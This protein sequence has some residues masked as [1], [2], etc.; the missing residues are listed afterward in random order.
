[1]NHLTEEQLSACVD[2]ALPAAA[3]AAAEAH[4]AGC[5]TCRA[6]LETMRAA[7]TLFG[8]VL[9][10]DP[11]DAYF[12]TFASRVAE[13]IGAE[14][15]AAPA[16]AAAPR[17][18]A[19]EV[20]GT[21]RRPPRS[22]A[23]WWD[24]ASWFTAPAR[25]AWVG[26]VA[27]VVVVAGVA[28][29]LARE[30]GVPDLRDAKTLQGSRQTEAREAAPAAPPAASREAD[31]R[32]ARDA[33][34]GP[35]AESGATG[36]TSADATS[37]RI[38]PPSHAQQ[39]RRLPGG[40]EVPVPRG[41]VPPFAQP[42]SP[43]PAPQ[44]ADGTVKV[45]RPQRAAPLDAKAQETRAAA[46]NETTTP[47]TQTMAKRATSSLG[48][49]GTRES[50]SGAAV[51]SLQLTAPGAC[52]V[53]VD[54]QGRPIARAQV[55]L[56]DRGVTATTSDAGRFCFDVAQGDYDLTVL[57]VGFTPLRR[58]VRLGDP[59]TP[60]R[61]VVQTVEVLAPASPLPPRPGAP[62]PP[63]G[64]GAEL[65][66]VPT[67]PA[68]VPDDLRAT[69][70]DARRLMIEAGA[71]PDAGRYE[72]AVEAWNGVI[73]AL[74]DG[75]A[76]DLEAREH[77]ADA[78]YAAWVL[79]ATPARNAAAREALHDLTVRLPEGP[80]RDRVRRLLARLVP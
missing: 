25:L 43:A 21:E 13:R 40:E 29:M 73:A 65:L 2:G 50:L 41:D 30:G 32:L 63:P 26:G 74:P 31:D 5:E 78:L 59:N 44:S 28:L 36:R 20:P 12:R 34:T 64:V 18:P 42:P 16:A 11:G 48:A 47:T 70:N 77:R 69:W 37:E 23:P 67:A 60:V 7:D 58:S 62:S 51:P 61:L 39:V 54:A 79:E 68:D 1:M 72:A 55:V 76:A 15:A 14:S 53:V 38:A 27:A 57:A 46:K 8:E 9:T 75:G 3:Q 10:H 66:P 52:G 22:G 71:D 49:S 6:A 35:A 80:R 19:P 4:L 24:I 17:A 33:D 56:G 45:A